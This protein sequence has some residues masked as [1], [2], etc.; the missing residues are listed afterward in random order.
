MPIS[1]AMPMSDGVWYVY[2]LQCTGGRIYTGVTP[3][4]DR[5]MS[6]HAR[7]KGAKFT[8]INRPE[9]LL[10]AKPYQDKRTAMQV[11]AQIKRMPA[12]GKRVLAGQWSEQYPIDEAAQELLAVE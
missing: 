12:A 6:A 7:G 2:L 10:G 8:K 1:L 3:R 4:L 5:R 11:E 9:R